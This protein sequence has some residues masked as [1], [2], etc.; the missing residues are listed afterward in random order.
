MGETRVP[1]RL[2]SPGAIA[3]GSDDDAKYLIVIG[4]TVG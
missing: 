1:H 2:D 4:A 3:F